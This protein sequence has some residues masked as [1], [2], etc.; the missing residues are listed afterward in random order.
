MKNARSNITVTDLGFFFHTLTV[1]IY[2]TTITLRTTHGNATATI[3]GE[4][5]GESY[6]NFNFTKE[7]GRLF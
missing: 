2:S 4:N 7:V 1:T 6:R 5:L 3:N